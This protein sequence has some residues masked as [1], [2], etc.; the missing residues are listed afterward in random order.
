[1][2]QLSMGMAGLDMSHFLMPEDGG[3]PETL[4]HIKG[5]P[6]PSQASGVSPSFHSSYLLC[7][8]EM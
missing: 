6:D 3:I 4:G 5:G 8:P 1:M 7:V 2:L